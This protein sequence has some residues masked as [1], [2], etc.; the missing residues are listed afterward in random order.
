VRPVPEESLLFR[1]AAEAAAA[2]RSQ[3][4]RNGEAIER[5]AERLRAKPPRAVVTCARGSSD[6]AA[7]FAKYLVETRAGVLTAS[8][9]PAVSTLYGAPLDVRDCLFLVISQSGRSPDLVAATDSAKERGATVVALVNAEDAPI[10][11]IAHCT[12]PLGAFPEHGVAATKSFIASLAAIVHLVAAWTRDGALA[13]ALQAAPAALE[14]AWTL[15]WS[16]AVDRLA[17]AGHLYVIGRGTGFAIAQEAALKL[18]EACGLHA[19]PFSGAE[20][21]HGPQA[22]L[23]ESFPVLVFAQEDEAQGGLVELARDLAAR[24]VPVIFA[25][26]RVDG[27]L[28]LPTIEAHPAI[29]PLLL[30]QSFYRLAN[31][32]AFARGRDPDRPPHLTKVTRTL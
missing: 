22:L 11:K 20:V 14:Q 7:T 24:G 3:L 18:K 23:D 29:E 4:A 5:L 32:L 17:P 15:D 26:A 2:V 21:R 16:A 28:S 30:V 13:T 6:H 10:A 27:A 12:L 19:E 8:T 9:A 25:G 1:E 31:A